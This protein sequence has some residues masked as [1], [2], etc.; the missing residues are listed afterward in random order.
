MH[1]ALVT[2][3]D[4]A[5]K[6]FPSPGKG[7][8]YDLPEEQLISKSGLD[9]VAQSLLHFHYSLGVLED[10]PTPTQIIG[11]AFHVITLEP[12]LTDDKIV[13]L[14]DHGDMRSS[15]N[16]KLRE[17]WLADEGRGRQPLKEVDYNT[18]IAMR[19]SVHAHP[20][21]RKLMRKGRSEVTAV[22]TDPATG[23]RAKARA[24]RLV[25]MDGVF[26]DL[27]SALSAAP[28]EFRRAAANNRYHVQDAFYSRAFE[29][30]GVHI[31]NFV[32]VVCEKT[33]PYAVACYQL[34]DTARMRG[35]Q[36]Y[37]RE[38][39]LLADA[40]EHDRWPGYS[41]KV[42]DLSLPKWATPDEAD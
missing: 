34:D 18:V 3:P 36:L 15:T 26:V 11:R 24:D 22:W 16:R 31:S 2:L 23:L 19:D 21:A 7:I 25:E 28:D 32:F 14:P 1:P 17:A 13:V 9:V 5:A 42:E 41:S 40:I 4:W 39:R 30:N 33:P 35:E 37:M 10:D 38:M 20:A 12:D 29:E 27:K 6:F 8:V